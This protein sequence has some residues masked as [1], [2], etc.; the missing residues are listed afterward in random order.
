MFNV[1]EVIIISTVSLGCG[2][3][4]TK[5]EQ[6]GLLKIVF[7]VILIIFVGTD[8]N[9]ILIAG[10]SAIVGILY[11]RDALEDFESPLAS[12]T[13]F[14]ENRKYEKTFRKKV[15]H[16]K[17]EQEQRDRYQEQQR[18]EQEARR[19]EEARQHREQTSR[20]EQARKKQESEAEQRRRERAS[21]DE[22][23][24]RNREEARRERE[25][26]EA[27][28]QQ[29]NQQQ[30]EQEQEAVDNRSPEE[31][32]GLKPGFT[33]EDLKKAYQSESMRTHPDKWNGKPDHI[34]VMMQ[35]EQK[36]INWAYNQLKK[37]F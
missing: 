27:R 16:L 29:Q 9:Q 6:H 2:Y 20:E 10:T 23:E 30:Q 11:A 31:V 18:Q 37:K 25:Q 22:R 17:F 1:S 34:R 4:I 8:Y 36:K 15:E 12:F 5:A 3:N 33:A 14:L 28:K 21:R 7:L 19:A 13:N 26:E 32:L 35:E 24:Q